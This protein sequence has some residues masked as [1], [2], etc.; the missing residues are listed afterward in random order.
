MKLEN[1]KKLIKFYKEKKDGMVKNHQKVIDDGM[2]PTLPFELFIALMVEENELYDWIA[3]NYYTVKAS[4]DNF[5]TD[6]IKEIFGIDSD[7]FCYF[8]RCYEQSFKQK[9]FITNLKLQTNG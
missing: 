7:L 1:V 4:Y 2:E 3:D 8:L 6:E 9:D 5:I